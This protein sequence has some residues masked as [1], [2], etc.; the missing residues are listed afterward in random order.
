MMANLPLGAA[1]EHTKKFSFEWFVAVHA[2]IPFV[3]SLRK[4]G[5]CTFNLCSLS[6]NLCYLASAGFLHGRF[7]TWGT[8][9]RR[10]GPSTC[11]TAA[12]LL[13]APCPVPPSRPYHRPPPIAATPAPAPLSPALT[14]ALKAPGLC[15]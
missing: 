9:I 13:R 6:L 12:F 3:V 1:R 7:L 2:S 14:G 11:P 10:H 5:W 4:A 8:L 15:A